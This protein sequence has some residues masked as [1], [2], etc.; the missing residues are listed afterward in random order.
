MNELIETPKPLTKVALNYATST[1]GLVALSGMAIPLGMWAAGFLTMAWGVGLSV[2]VAIISFLISVVAFGWPEATLPESEWMQEN[3]ALSNVPTIDFA[4]R[5][6]EKMRSW[7]GS[8]EAKN[9]LPQEAQKLLLNFC[10]LITNLISQI[11]EKKESIPSNLSFEVFRIA[12]VHMPN[13]L[14]SYLSI[15]QHHAASMINEDGK[16]ANMMLTASMKDLIT[17]IQKT[18]LAINAKNLEKL[19]IETKFLTEKYGTKH[20]IVEH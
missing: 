6:N 3:L 19:E 1:Q 13:A 7:A 10:S 11:E 16:T 12:T 14:Q 20:N 15:P 9:R 4:K 18:D 17:T 5:T 8:P 2:P